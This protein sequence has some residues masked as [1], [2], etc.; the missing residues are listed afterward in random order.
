MFILAVI[1]VASFSLAMLPGATYYYQFPIGIIGTIYGNSMLVLINSGMLISS[2]EIPLTIISAF[3]FAT[4]PDDKK[5]NV[6]HANNGDV[7]LDTTTL[8]GPLE[9]SHLGAV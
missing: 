8:A 9:S 6:I 3:K 2:E 1:G 7:T 4:V 5:I